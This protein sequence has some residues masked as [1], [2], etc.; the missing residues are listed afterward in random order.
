MWQGHDDGSG[1]AG[2]V[3]DGAAGAGTVR[4]GVLQ[5]RLGGG[6]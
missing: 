6:S 3:D 2:D 4:F 1:A 5:L